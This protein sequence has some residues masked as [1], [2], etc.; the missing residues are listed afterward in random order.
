MYIGA[1]YERRLQKKSY[2]RFQLG[3]IL[4]QYPCPYE[5][6][7]LELRVRQS[8]GLNLTWTGGNGG[9]IARR[10]KDRLAF[11]QKVD[12]IGGLPVRVFLGVDRI[13]GDAVGQFGRQHAG[14]ATV[15]FK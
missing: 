13:K 4:S 12:L 6:G 5:T 3:Y 7:C 9:L 15:T 1:E 14:L 8:T 11:S 10:G 2:Y